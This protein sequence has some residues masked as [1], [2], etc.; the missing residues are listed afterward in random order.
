MKNKIR[1]ILLI[2]LIFSGMFFSCKSV[3]NFAQKI[4][5][6]KNAT[7]KNIGY[8]LGASADAH[9]TAAEDI[10]PEQEYYIGRSV[11]A[12]LL[13]TYK[14]YTKKPALT[15]YLNDICAA[16]TINSPRPDIYNGYHVAILDSDEINAFATPG[17]HI[18]VTYA[19]VKAG[20]TEDALAGVISHEVAHIQL[21]HSINAIRNSRRTQASL[22]TTTAIAGVAGGTDVKQ[23]TDALEESFMELV[24]TLVSNGYSQSQEFDADNTALSLMAGAGY[25][26]SGLT[27]MLMSLGS[28]IRS[29]S[30]FGKTHPSPAE[31]IANVQKSIGK[32]KVANTSSSRQKRFDV[33]MK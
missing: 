1:V 2:I 5:T 10:N 31:R 3:S 19:L 28:V 11:A 13:S 15:T 12:N 22:V 9:I 14:L 29:D 32:Y 8:A 26:P 6:S 30:G 18:Y 16:I 17:G 4:G 33:A 27:D 21:K 7:L 23:L 20:K 24:R 25:S